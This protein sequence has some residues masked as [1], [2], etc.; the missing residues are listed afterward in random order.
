MS[1]LIKEVIQYEDTVENT[2]ETVDIVECEA[3][4]VTFTGFK[5]YLMVNQ[6]LAGK[7]YFLI[8]MS[9]DAS[10]TASV[11]TT[12]TVY[13]GKDAAHILWGMGFASQ[14]TQQFQKI[15]PIE[16]KVARTLQI[17]DKIQFHWVGDAA[18]LARFTLFGSYFVETTGGRIHEESA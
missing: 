4:E 7:G 18:S 17:K 8:T 11:T 1:P 15:V 12:S 9:P 6:D 2:H 10:Y 5:G 14:G 16:I 3:G 13:R